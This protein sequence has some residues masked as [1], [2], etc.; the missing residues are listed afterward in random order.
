M[1]NT[2]I[3][4]KHMLAKMIFGAIIIVFMFQTNAF[5][6]T[7]KVTGGLAIHTGGMRINNGLYTR[8]YQPVP[9][10]DPEVT[11]SDIKPL[12]ASAMS[13]GLNLEVIGKKWLFDLDLNYPFKAKSEYFAKNMG[14]VF[15]LGL[16]RGK[17]FNEKLGIFIGSSFFANIANI[18]AGSTAPIINSA[19]DGEYSGPAIVPVLPRGN[20]SVELNGV[21][22]FNDNLVFRT[23]VA[24]CLGIV[25]DTEVRESYDGDAT[26][27]KFE[28][29][30]GV[31]L[32]RFM[33]SV[34]YTWLSHKLSITDLV[35]VNYGNGNGNSIDLSVIPENTKFRFSYLS[36]AIAFSLSAESSSY[37]ITTK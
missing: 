32:S 12:K 27:F 23:N 34:K 33:F 11:Y 10:S 16:A 35:D 31:S 21:Y 6:Q 29:G 22:H 17:T 15:N 19:P 18:S 2:K 7:T 28:N 37:T 5:A 8:L 30:L 4:V 13:V 20:L 25:P 3:A 14:Y 24:Y 1:L 9:D 36:V 26:G